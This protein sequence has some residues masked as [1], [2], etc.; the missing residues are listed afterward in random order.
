[1]LFDKDTV[2]LAWERTN[3]QCECK[4]IGCQHAGGRCTQPLNEK[5]LNDD[6]PGGWYVRAVN[7]F[8]PSKLFNLETVCSECYNRLAQNAEARDQIFASGKT[9][10]TRL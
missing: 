9:R 8:G 1:M 3:G 5:M 6:D 4:R 7:E 10:P 2:K